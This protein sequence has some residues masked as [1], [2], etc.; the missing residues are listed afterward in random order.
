MTNQ[1][2]GPDCGS[3]CKLEWRN[4]SCNSSCVLASPPH[5]PPTPY[6]KSSD[7]EELQDGPSLGWGCLSTLQPPLV[8]PLDSHDVL[9]DISASVAGLRCRCRITV[10]RS[11][12][13]LVENDYVCISPSDKEVMGLS[14]CWFDC[15]MITQEADDK[16]SGRF[17]RRFV[18]NK[19]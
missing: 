4:S 13:L 3:G 10:N 18:S 17:G 5:P 14:L 12:V 7:L 6:K 11:T 1:P 9:F 16:F 8:A 2:K 15:Q 19:D